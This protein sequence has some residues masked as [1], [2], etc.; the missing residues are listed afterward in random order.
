M[1]VGK[2]K[3]PLKVQIGEHL[4][5]INDKGTIP[6][7]PLD[8]HFA[9]CHGVSSLVMKIKGIFALKLL[10]RRG[11]LDRILLQKEKWW[12][13]RL[14]SLVLVGLN[15]ELNLHVFLET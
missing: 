3:R 5:E 10:I 14:K 6:E 2:T 11:D 7:K 13:Y 4:R 12:I 1:Y 15:T 9:L 8:K